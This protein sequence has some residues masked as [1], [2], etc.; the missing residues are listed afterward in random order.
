MMNGQ[1][2]PVVEKVEIVQ[3]LV[4]YDRRQNLLAVASEVGIF[5]GS[6][7]F[8]YRQECPKSR[9]DGSLEC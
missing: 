1:G 3:S 9:L 7:V 5:W 2:A 6:S 4:M 8:P